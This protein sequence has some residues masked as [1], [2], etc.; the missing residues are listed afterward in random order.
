MGASQMLSPEAVAGLSGNSH[1]SAGR[2]LV[3]G[4]EYGFIFNEGDWPGSSWSLGLHGTLSPMKGTGWV[5]TRHWARMGL[6]HPWRGLA[7]RLSKKQNTAGQD[8]PHGFPLF[9]AGF[10]LNRKV[11]F[12]NFSQRGLAFLSQHFQAALRA[13]SLRVLA[14]LWRHHPPTTLTKV[15]GGMPS[16]KVLGGEGRRQSRPDCSLKYAQW[17]LLARKTKLRFPGSDTNPSPRPV[18][19]SEPGPLD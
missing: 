2:L 16:L 17:V 9:Q 7:S 15:L 13:G 1:Q 19:P 12:H 8:S 18:L 5:T 11:K 4:P 3:T 6:Y 10:P 14:R